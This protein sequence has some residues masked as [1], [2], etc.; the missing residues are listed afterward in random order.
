M[1]A[2]IPKTNDAC[3]YQYLAPLSTTVKLDKP[4]LHLPKQKENA[5]FILFAFI[6]NVT[7]KVN[8]N[9]IDNS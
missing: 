9:M 1:C 3:H 2:K 5:I 4:R 7:V 8:C 6:H